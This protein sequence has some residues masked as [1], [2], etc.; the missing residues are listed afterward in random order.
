MHAVRRLMTAGTGAKTPAARHSCNTAQPIPAIAASVSVTP[1][2]F[3][4]S[5]FRRNP[6]SALALVDEWEAICVAGEASEL[7]DS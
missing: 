2:V 1:N 6:Y 5:R 3:K 4:P 7:V